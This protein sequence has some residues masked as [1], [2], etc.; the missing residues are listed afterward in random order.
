MFKILK[1]GNVSKVFIDCSF[2]SDKEE[3]D[4]VDGC[5]S[6]FGVD[7]S[8]LDPRFWDFVDEKDFL[9]KKESLKKEFGID[10][11]IAEAFEGESGKPFP[12]FFQSNRNGDAKGIMEVTL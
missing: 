4:D 7:A 5:W 1:K 3:P 9:L 11:Y 8:K 2:V 10:F 6:T 12:C